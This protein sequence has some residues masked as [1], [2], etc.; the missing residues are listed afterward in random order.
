MFTNEFEV[1]CGS[2]K[3]S[4]AERMNVLA[5]AVRMGDA[6]SFNELYTLAFSKAKAVAKKKGAR[7]E[8]V[9]DI[10]QT[11]MI[12]LYR[13]IAKVDYVSTWV[14]T[15]V[16]RLV[17]DMSRKKSYSCE[18][19]ELDA[20]CRVDDDDSC[21]SDNSK[22][23]VDFRVAANPEASLFR[24]AERETVMEVLSLLPVQQR[25][26]LYLSFV[27]QKKQDE[28]AGVLGISRSTVAAHIR[29]GK[30]N[31][32]REFAAHYDVSLFGIKAAYGL[33]AA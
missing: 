28:I 20:P 22:V 12:R 33:E 15:V 18:V 14:T 10:A 23:V 11:A 5:K 13:D 31:F 2:A 3:Q 27:E 17:I 7:G 29:M 19:Y 6:D 25:K 32:R 9:F 4:D 26:A 24:E 16:S 30:A 21:P 1:K 8:E